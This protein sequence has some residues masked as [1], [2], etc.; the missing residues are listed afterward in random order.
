MHKQGN[1]AS[2]FF[3]EAHC[4]NTVN[5]KLSFTERKETLV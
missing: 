1:Q 4:R 2:F 5:A 3:G